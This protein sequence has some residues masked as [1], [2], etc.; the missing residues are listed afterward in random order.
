MIGQTISH[1][2]ILDKVGEGGMGVVYK[3]EDTK[4]RRTV[5]LK[6]LPP[7]ATENRERFLREA[8]AAASLNHPNI[9]TIYEID[10]EHGFIAMEFIEG[11]S[12]KEKIEARPLPL[13]QALD[14]A[15][16]TCAG[17]QAAHENNIV[18]RDIKPANI[19]ITV[20]GQ[21]KIMDF[22]LAQVA[23]ATRLT[24][25]GTTMGT[26]AYM[27]PEQTQGQPTD[28]RTD[29]WSLGAVLYEMLSGRLPFPGDSAPAV[30]YS[31]VNSDPEP[32]TALRSGLP[33]EIDRIAAKALRKNQA[34]R[35][36]HI[37][38]LAVDL[39][40]IG[41]ARQSRAQ[42]AW[43][44]PAIASAALGL[45]GFGA[46]MLSPSSRTIESLAVLPFVNQA[47]S[48][49]MEYLGDG[50]TESLMGTL[51]R[52]PKLRV[53]AR[54]TMFRFKARDADPRAVGKE[55][56]VDAVLTGRVLR[57]ADKVQVSVE[58]VNSGDGSRLW[59]AQ[60]NRPFQ[61]IL[62][63][64]DEIAREISG[65]LR[66][67]LDG[68]QNARLT[69][70]STDNPDAY[71]TYLKGLYQ[72]NKRSPEAVRQSVVLFQE[73]IEKDPSYALA[74]AGLSEA[75]AILAVIGASPSA[76]AAPK[77]K[78]AALRAVELDSSLAEGHTALA[79]VLFRFYWD[80]QGAELAFQRSIELNPN[81]AV[82]HHRRSLY[83]AALQRHDEAIQEAKR[84]VEIDPLS[85]TIRGHQAWEYFIARRYTEAERLILKVLADEPDFPF[86]HSVAGEIYMGQRK[87]PEAI[88]SFERSAHWNDANLGLAI[89]QA[90]GGQRRLA[91]EKLA[92][93]EARLG[94]AGASAFWAGVLSAALGHTDRAFQLF[95]RAIEEHDEGV[96][97][98]NTWPALDP[99]RSDPRFAVLVRRIGL[100]PATTGSPP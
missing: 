24:Q 6:F 61:D 84:A 31:I 32:L 5:A 1:Y 58:L 99:L 39:R 15:V 11:S 53:I 37:E 2:R 16:Q 95:A 88:A 93:V 17:L 19:M 86:L 43:M 3:A 50:I 66:Q 42:P 26:P 100:T 82:L 90:R 71:Q 52:V 23:G 92:K 60:Y 72:W 27:S 74:Y 56:K 10:D 70:H 47:A 30:S 87:Y 65:H 94:Q 25:S 97:L 62:T 78:A 38:D 89:A 33:K 21:V 69:K 4:L 44:K 76:D 8:Q 18:H 98:L 67:R 9:C 54:S 48:A 64:Q 7:Y 40:H 22:G 35:Y 14:I 79:H 80:W 51:S 12:V 91:E 28:R 83:L 96:T 57:K 85:P 29:I 55:L 73:A 63:V 81:L 45:A 36:A 34:E 13:E 41:R 77:A 68:Q 46:W 59:G 49:D 20:Q 75:H